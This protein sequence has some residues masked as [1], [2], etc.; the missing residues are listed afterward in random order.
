MHGCKGQKQHTSSHT[1]LGGGIG[2]QALEPKPCTKWLTYEM[3]D[4]LKKSK[5]AG[6]C[7][8]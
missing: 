3:A 7:V 1:M 5:T 2:G 4:L 8:I 6:M